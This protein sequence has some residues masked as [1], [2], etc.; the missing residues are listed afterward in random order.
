MVGMEHFLSEGSHDTSPL[1]HSRRSAIL[2]SIKVVQDK[3]SRL[4][5]CLLIYVNAINYQ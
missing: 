5:G 1:R 2:R 4:I 3:N